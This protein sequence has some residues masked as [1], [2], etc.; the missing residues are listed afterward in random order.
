MLNKAVPFLMPSKVLSKLFWIFAFLCFLFLIQSG[1]NITLKKRSLFELQLVES[2]P[3]LFQDMHK[4]YPLFYIAYQKIIHAKNDDKKLATISDALEIAKKEHFNNKTILQNI[5]LVAANI[6]HSRWHIVYAIEK[7]KVAQSLVYNKNIDSQ[8]KEL[9]KYL[10]KV[11][12]ERGLND[13]YIATKY[14]GPAKTFSGKILVAYVFVDDGL[15]TRWSNKTKL[16]TQQVMALVQRWQSKK[17]AEYNVDDIEFVNK[18]FVARKNP[19]LKAPKLVSFK[20]SKIDVEQFIGSVMQSL[21]ENSIGGFIEKQMQK[22]GADQGVVFLHSNL[23]QRSFA[24]RCAY[25][26]R[27]RVFKNGK[28]EV[29]MISKCRDEYVMLM[30]KVKRNRW[31]KMHYAQAHEMM[32]VFGAADLY[33]IKK[34]SGYA[35]TDIMNFQSKSLMYSSVDPITAYAIGWQKVPPKAPFKILER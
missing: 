34:A 18:T 27:K 25:T 22:V 30:E 4:N 23:D 11:D 13:D 24:Q 2:D 31:D 8:I 28:Y 35:V 10:T 14:S 32:H 12:I 29:Q 5:N 17:A 7:F 16:R 26:H 15:K 1:N 21:G 9:R 3:E 6:H 20:S 33:N 19:N